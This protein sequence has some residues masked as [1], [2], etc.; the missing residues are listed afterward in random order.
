MAFVRITLEDGTLMDCHL[1]A[2]TLT[3]GRHPENDLVLQDTSISSRHAELRRE[4]DGFWIRDMGSTNKTQVNG[5]DIDE[6]L[7]ADRDKIAFG[8]LKAVYYEGRPDEIEDEP[9][10][11]ST[12]TTKLRQDIARS[13][14]N[15]LPVAETMAVHLQAGDGSA[16]AATSPAQQ[17]RARA[18]EKRSR[19]GRG[20]PDPKFQPKKPLLSDNIGLVTFLFIAGFFV[21]VALGLT[22][23]H[24]RDTGG[25]LPADIWNKMRFIEIRRADQEPQQQRPIRGRQT[26]VPPVDE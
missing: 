14:L 16:I 1:D 19:S 8:D 9:E 17:Q 2:K 23:R 7:L 21:S 11:E 6:I 5:E 20:G 13:Q 24:A 25:F 4:P 18:R 12:A 10:V 26:V 3:I 22:V 15:Q